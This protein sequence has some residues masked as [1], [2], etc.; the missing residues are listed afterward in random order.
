MTE[1]KSLPWR[2][3]SMNPFVLAAVGG[4][5]I[6]LS[7]V[8]LMALSG[9]I[10][11][12]SGIVAGLLPPQTA[13]DRSWRLA[14]V[15][16]LLLAPALLRVATGD[17]GIGPPVVAIPMLAVAGFLVGAG[18]TLGGG[19][20]SGHGICGIARLSVRSITAVAVFLLAALITVFLL[21]HVV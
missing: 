1:A 20:T 12:V 21:R 6:G 8:L 3:R 14:F 2:R 11:G 18:T 19:C 5:L 7:A 16:G 15:A 10:A 17:D 13:P 9:R 4:V